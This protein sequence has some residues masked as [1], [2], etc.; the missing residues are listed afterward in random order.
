MIPV[1]KSK[2]KGTGWAYGIHVEMKYTH[3]VF[4]GENLKSRDYLKDLDVAKK[5]ILKWL[6]KKLDQ[7]V[8]AGLI[9]LSTGKSDQL[10]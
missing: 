5:V 6:L 7:R 4:M 1:I 2:G 3:R 10:L 9:W 8:W